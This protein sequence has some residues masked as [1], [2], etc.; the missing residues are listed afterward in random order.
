M[1]DF[2]LQFLQILINLAITTEKVTLM[3]KLKAIRTEILKTK[4]LS[5]QI[6]NAKICCYSTYNY[7]QS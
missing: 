2:F 3:S 7:N 6:K 1:I 4:R 5:I